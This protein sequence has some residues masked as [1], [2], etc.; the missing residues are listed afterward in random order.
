MTLLKRITGIG[1]ASFL[2]LGL[3]ACSNGT[4]SAEQNDEDQTIGDAVGYEI[5]GVDPGSGHME[6]T[7]QV[8]TEYDLSDWDLTSGNG[9]AMTAALKRAY[10]KKEPI[11]VTGWNP[12]WKF[13]TFDLKFLE[14]P[15]LIY[16][17]EEQ[18]YTYARL[19]LK[20]DMP[21]AY[22]ILERFHWEADDMREI[23]I[24]I[25]G[26]VAPEDA[27][28]HW[29]E[30]NT[31]KISEWTDGV[32]SVDGD[33][34]TLVLAPWDSEIASHN[35]LKL[36]LED[37]GYDV[38]LSIVEPGPL[39]SALASGGADASAAFWLPYTHETYLNK[40]EGQFEEIGLNMTG[41]RQGLVVP[42]YMEDVNS[43]E[44]LNN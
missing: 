35:M 33:K 26:G 2:A 3:A 15:K 8:L 38:T 9:A 17:D 43:I 19:G 18:I 37:K 24:E 23:M 6:A 16:G 32:S 5:V 11:I 29:V 41:V 44:D 42:A 28:L 4:T 40:Y 1:A 21:E 25:E 20:E 36:V 12:H 14:D 34:I 22:T 7:E 39:F 10:D 31:D 30:G 13:T 27:A